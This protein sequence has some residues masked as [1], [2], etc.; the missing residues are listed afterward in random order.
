MSKTDPD[1]VRRLIAGLKMPRE[2][3]CGWALLALGLADRDKS[4]ARSAL[5]ESILLIDGLGGPRDL[6]ERVN[7]RLMVADN[8]AASILPIVEKVTPERLNEVFWK[9]VALMPKVDKDPQSVVRVFSPV[10]NATFLARY[11]RQVAD[12]LLTQATASRPLSPSGDVRYVLMV[13]RAKAVVDPR[14][15]WRCSRRC[16][17]SVRMRAFRRIAGSIKTAPG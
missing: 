17:P 6:A 9:A 13:I 1:R 15:P 12:L 8:P 16:R 7:P 5:A 2:Q 4:S 10:D 11:D 3:P 14:A